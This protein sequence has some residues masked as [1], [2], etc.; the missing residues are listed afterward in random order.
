MIGILILI[1]GKSKFGSKL[2]GMQNTRIKNKGWCGD[3]YLHAT[4]LEFGNTKEYVPT[5]E[6]T[7][8][9]YL[10]YILSHE[11]KKN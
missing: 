11:G 6:R 1:K 9:E 10:H 8:S 7:I 3:L 4:N 5:R 2:V